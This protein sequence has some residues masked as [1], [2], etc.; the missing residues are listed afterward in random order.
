MKF[1]KYYNGAQWRGKGLTRNTGAF[2]SDI[3]P[4]FD[5][6]ELSKMPNNISHD[7]LRALWD[8]NRE[9]PQY[10]PKYYSLIHFATLYWN[11]TYFF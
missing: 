7:I 6:E 5:L 8:S 9:P 10:E 2:I 3:T 4:A 1:T 11:K